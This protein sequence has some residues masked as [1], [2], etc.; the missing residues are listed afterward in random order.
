MIVDVEVLDRH[1]KFL[2]NEVQHLRSTGKKWAAEKADRLVCRWIF[3]TEFKGR[4]VKDAA[5][6]MA[7]IDRIGAGREG[8]RHEHD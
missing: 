5:G 7:E 8:R 3:G 2:R 6:I 4:Q 1:L